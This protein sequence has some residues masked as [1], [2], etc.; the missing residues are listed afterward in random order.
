MHIRLAFGS[1]AKARVSRTTVST[2][3]AA[4]LIDTKEFRN[5]SFGRY[6][7]AGWTDD[8]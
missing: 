7:H 1:F 4:R 8:S 6:A 3:F 2:L 5:G